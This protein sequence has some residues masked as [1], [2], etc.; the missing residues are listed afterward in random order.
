MEN[1]SIVT[2]VSSIDKVEGWFM[3]IGI[4]IGWMRDEDSNHMYL[5]IF[6]R[7]IKFKSGVGVWDRRRKFAKYVH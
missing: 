7:C 3:N 1:Q 4:G 5:Y 2:R 6:I